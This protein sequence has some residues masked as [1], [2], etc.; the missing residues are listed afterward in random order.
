MV[1]SGR[2]VMDYK[3][4]VV[5]FIFD[6]SMSYVLLMKKNRPDWMAGYFNGVGGHTKDYEPTRATMSRETEEEVGIQIPETVWVHVCN[7]INYEKEAIIDCY[8]VATNKFEFACSQTDEFIYPIPVFAY[9]HRNVLPDVTWLIPLSIAV[10]K[11]QVRLTSYII[12]EK[13]L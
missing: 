13:T 8:A 6:E 10:L 2:S 7:I 9:D 12:E 11:R 5:G 3:T 1:L 4:M